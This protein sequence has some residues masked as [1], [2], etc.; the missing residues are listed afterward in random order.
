MQKKSSIVFFCASVFY[1]V[2]EKQ[3]KMNVLKNYV[4]SSWNSADG[5]AVDH[6]VN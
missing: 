3:I 5:L 1:I 6:K 4:I 2:H